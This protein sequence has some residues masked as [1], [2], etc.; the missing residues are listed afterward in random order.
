M[1]RKKI[2]GSVYSQ[3]SEGKKTKSHKKLI[4]WR[5]QKGGLKKKEAP[6]FVWSLRQLSGFQISTNKKQALKT[7]QFPRRVCSLILTSHVST[8]DN[9]SWSSSERWEQGAAKQAKREYSSTA[10]AVNSD[11]WMIMLFPIPSFPHENFYCSYTFSYHF[12]APDGRWARTLSLHFKEP[13][14]TSDGTMLHSESLGF[15][16]M[17]SLNGLCECLPWEGD[18]VYVWE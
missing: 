7:V 17:K 14:Q 16:Q 13:F 4:P 15:E 2:F 3:Q 12:C 6:V 10:R 9:K 11:R 18:S 8:E 5:D 1:S